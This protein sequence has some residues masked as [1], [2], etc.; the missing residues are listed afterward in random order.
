MFYSDLGFSHTLHVLKE[1]RRRG[2]LTSITS[3]PQHFLSN[4]TFLGQAELA[5]RKKNERA[6]TTALLAT[7]ELLAPNLAENKQQ[8]GNR[9]KAL[10]G[11]A[12]DQLLQDVI[13][14]VKLARRSP[15]FKNV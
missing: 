10:R 2:A 8:P 6:N 3:N 4:P 1:R 9:S 13:H 7:L 12:K 15:F 5:Q 14:A 11:R